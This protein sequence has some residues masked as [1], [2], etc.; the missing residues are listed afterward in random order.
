MREPSYDVVETG[1]PLKGQ[2]GLTI[3]NAEL[4]PRFTAMLIKNIEIKPSPQWL[5]RR[6][7]AAGERPINNIVDITNYVMLE[8]GQPLHAFDY[9][10]LV[11]RA[12]N[13]MPS[14]LTRTAK[15][16]EKVTT[17][18]GVEHTLEYFT[19][20]VCDSAGVLSIAGVMG[21]DDGKVLPT[22]KNVL[23]EAANWNYI[24]IRRTMTTQ[25]MNSEAGL[26][27]SRKCSLP[28]RCVASGGPLN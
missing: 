13:K 19:V 5:Q 27:F 14:L 18:D 9:D 6:L 20:L 3:R 21:G 16:G 24:N 8:I 4:N 22:T 1:A 10:V 17:L 25:K 12:G 28:R 23:L 2:L 26:R 15:P 7:I 11:Q